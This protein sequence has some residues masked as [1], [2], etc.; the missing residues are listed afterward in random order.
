M[1]PNRFPV[2]VP[3]P[4]SLCFAKYDNTQ[5]SDF[6]R[7]RIEKR[8]VRNSIEPLATPHR[9]AA[10]TGFCFI[11]RPIRFDRPFYIH[12]RTTYRALSDDFKA[13]KRFSSTQVTTIPDIVG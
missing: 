6:V 3:R 9:P 10:E 2:L 5:I 13:F 8:R 4:V 11:F 1:F 7:S 12:A